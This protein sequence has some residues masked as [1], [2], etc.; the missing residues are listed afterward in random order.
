MGAK[1]L[2]MQTVTNTIPLYAMQTTLVHKGI[3]QELE[4]I[5]RAFLWGTFD[6]EQHCHPVAWETVCL[7]KMDGGLGVR[8]LYKTN[9]VTLARLCWRLLQKPQGLWAK[10]LTAKYGELGDQRGPSSRVTSCYT[11]K[12]ILQGYEAM[13]PG[14]Q[15][16]GGS[17]SWN[18]TSSEKFTSKSMWQKLMV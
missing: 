2:L 7:Y 3:T 12:S 5:N 10:V 13:R 9:L 17:V 16:L 1:I 14:L 4:R 8:N 11:W 15:N 18:F 6:G